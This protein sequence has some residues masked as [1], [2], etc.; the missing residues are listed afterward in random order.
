MTVDEI[1]KLM[2]FSGITFCM[3]GI[4]F[5]IMRILGKFADM[6]GDLRSTVQ[7]IGHIT[8]QFVEDYKA[9]SEAIKAISGGLTNINS[10]IIQ[11]LAKLSKLTS[12]IPGFGKKKDEDEDED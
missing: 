12:K 4:S 11:P 3:I 6:L 5:Q 1:V 7:N 8:T 10:G 2:I 9:I